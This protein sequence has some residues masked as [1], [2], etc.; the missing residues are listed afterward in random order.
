MKQI[1]RHY[2]YKKIAC[3]RR[4]NNVKVGSLEIVKGMTV[5]ELSELIKAFEEEFGVSAATCSVVAPGGAGC[6]RGSSAG[7]ADRI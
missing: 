7:G 1:A 4:K 6:R 5:L 2:A 3:K